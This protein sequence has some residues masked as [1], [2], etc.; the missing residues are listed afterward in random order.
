MRDLLSHRSGLARGELTWYGSEFDRDEIVRRVRF[1]VPSWSLRSQFGYQNIMYIA[2]GQIAAHVGKTTWDDF[3]RER[4][5]V[6]L[7]MQSSTTSIRM[8]PQGGDVATPHARCRTPCARSLGTST[9]PVPPARQLQRRDMSQWLRLQLGRGTHGGKR[10]I[11][12]K[13][14]EEMHTPQRYPARLRREANNPR[15]ISRRTGSLFVQ[16]YRGRLV[17]Q[18]GGN[19]DGFT[20]S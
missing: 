9:T 13:L 11:S 20:P 16:D 10:I 15:R 12:E 14:V 8:L 4:I 3:T 1:L 5:F 18:H 7:G 2:A 17:V 19:V 6:P